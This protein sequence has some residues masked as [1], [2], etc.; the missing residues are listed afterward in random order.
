[1]SDSFYIACGKHFDFQVTAV[2]GSLEDK[3]IGRLLSIG[4]VEI[5]PESHTLEANQQTCCCFIIFCALYRCDALNNKTE[6]TRSVQSGYRS[7]L[8]GSAAGHCQS[9]YAD[10]RKISNEFSL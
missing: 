3:G 7:D 9:I 1:M 5:G 8:W 10:P 6:V 2:A 4:V